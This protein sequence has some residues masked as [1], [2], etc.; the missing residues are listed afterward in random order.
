[1]SDQQ[2]A[3]RVL[4]YGSFLSSV[5][6]KHVS[7]WEAVQWFRETQDEETGQEKIMIDSE[8]LSIDSVNQK[9]MTVSPWQMYLQR[10]PELQRQTLYEYCATVCTKPLKRGS[11][12]SPVN[13]HNKETETGKV[14][15]P[16]NKTF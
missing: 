6:F 16:K 13:A 11:L 15:R 14:G 2:A 5:Q 4:N 9:A 1:M 8:R 10:G 3:A 7:P 12:T